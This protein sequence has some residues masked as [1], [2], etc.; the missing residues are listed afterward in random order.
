MSILR[1]VAEVFCPRLSEARWSAV[2]QKD[3]RTPRIAGRGRDRTGA[4]SWFGWETLS[5]PT[6]I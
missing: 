5:G 1:P 4:V 3:G 2:D 6:T